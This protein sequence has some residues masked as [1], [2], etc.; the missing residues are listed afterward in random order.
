MSAA[1]WLGWLL[2]AALLSGCLGSERGG[3]ESARREVCLAVLRQGLRGEEFW[4]AMHAAEALTLAGC[5]S[6]VRRFL[7]PR[8]EGEKDDQHRCGLARELVRAGDRGRAEVLW[9]V[10]AAQGSTGRVHAAESLYKVGWPRRGAREDLLRTAMGEGGDIRLRLMSAAA[11]AR[12]CE[13]P[14][15]VALLRDVAQEED[16]PEVY[17]LAAWALGRVGELGRDGPI[18][19][20]R[21]EGAEGELTRA[22]LEIAL[23]NLGDP[24][25]RVAVVGRLN[26][27][28]AMVRTY[29]AECAAGVE[30]P[31]AVPLL[32]QQLHDKVLDARIRAAQA[33]L[34]WCRRNRM[35]PSFP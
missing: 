21:L 33:L 32:T 31:G 17:R 25:A 11:L 24:T 9:E 6:E 28:D 4:P 30:L 19:R 12:W 29:A 2:S 8:L 20:R 34:M 10:L 27:P 15:A 7:E 13:E 22:F 3:G 5:G 16:D 18:L 23:A 35:A 14:A 26:S 1:R